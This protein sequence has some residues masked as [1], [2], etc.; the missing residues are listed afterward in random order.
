MAEGSLYDA[1]LAAGA[2]KQARGDLVEAIFL[3]RADR[4]TLPRTGHSGPMG[5][6]AMASDRRISATFKDAP[7]ARCWC[8]GRSGE[9]GEDNQGARVQDEDFI[10]SHADG[11]QATG[12]PA[13]IKLPHY[14]DFQSEPDP[15]CMLRR[16]AEGRATPGGR[17]TEPGLR[18]R[19]HRRRCPSRHRLREDHSANFARP[20][21]IRPRHTTRLRAA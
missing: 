16:Q 6:G 2:I 7:R 19:H 14:V 21:A 10:L 20:H 9:L 4:T 1:E 15:V 5:A 12:F 3:I 11:L 13:H 17:Y 8:A 18:H